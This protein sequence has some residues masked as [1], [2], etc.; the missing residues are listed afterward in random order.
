MIYISHTSRDYRTRNLCALSFSFNDLVAR[1]REREFTK[2]KRE[3]R[4]KTT[5]VRIRKMRKEVYESNRIESNSRLPFYLLLNRTSSEENA[6][7]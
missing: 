2:K 7:E 1:E 5:R 6:E 3:E 4:K